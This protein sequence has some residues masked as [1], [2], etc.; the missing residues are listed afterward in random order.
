MREYTPDEVREKVI[1]HVRDCV[2]YWETLPDK[3]QH[4][5]LD[6]L[7]FSILVMLDGGVLGLPGFQVMACPHPDDKAYHQENGENWFADV[8]ENKHDIAGCLHEIYS[9]NKDAS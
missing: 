9:M 6:G 3:T 7:A 8:P 4:E 2:R 5:R 1:D